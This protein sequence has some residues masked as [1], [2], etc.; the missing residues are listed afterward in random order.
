[1]DKIDTSKLTLD[2]EMKLVD[3]GTGQTVGKDYN[4]THYLNAIAQVRLSEA[5]PDLEANKAAKRRDAFYKAQAEARAETSMAS[6]VDP[7]IESVHFVVVLNKVS[8]LQGQAGNA[9]AAWFQ[10]PR[11]RRN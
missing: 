6:Y 3:T 4:V 11:E 5:K 8:T 9:L 1:M 10:V 7:R 2:S